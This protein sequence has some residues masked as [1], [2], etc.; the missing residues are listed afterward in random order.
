MKNYIYALICPI[1]GQPRY[2]GKTQ[3]PQHRLATHI[4]KARSGQTNHHCA[5]WIRQLLTQ[6]E[7]P[8]LEVIFEVPDGEA[9]QSHETRL[10]AEYRSSGFAL[11]NLTA[12][13]DGFSH[14][15]PEVVA[16]RAS[17]WR[18][19]MSDPA[20]KEN[21]RQRIAEAN[22]KPES[23]SRKSAA[24]KR[25]WED[26]IKGAS[27]LKGNSSP[28]ARAMRSA[29]ASLR[30]SDPEKRIEHGAR[31]A[32]VFGTPEARAA[33]SDRSREIHA[34]PGMTE[35]HRAAIRAAYDR[36]EVQAK[37]R[38]CNA[39][40]AQRPETRAKYSIK[41][42]KHWAENHDR[43]LAA[44][45][46]PEAREK[47]RAAIVASH[48]DPDVK[49]KRNAARWTPE[50]RAKQ[51]AEL[52]SRRDRMSAHSPEMIA[53]RNAAIKASW[54]RRKAAKEQPCPE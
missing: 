42:R 12:G 37:V 30:F 3:V 14:V 19:T 49:V 22:A 6:G 41:S 18:K 25:A 45:W 27:M 28:E 4:S 53:K 2:V 43:Q 20:R 47:H 5:C 32:E 36:P 16:K 17:A 9:W 52:A 46:T 13:G 39:E 48:A 10:I 15:T 11:T 29:S 38:A 23:R 31:M 50:A 51:A 21:M 1:S 44:M 35:K 40:I 8:T 34:R 24:A 33:Q 7:R 26:P 54:A